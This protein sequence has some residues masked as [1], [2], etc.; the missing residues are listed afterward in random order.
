MLFHIFNLALV[1]KDSVLRYGRTR[2]R[3]FF[4]YVRVVCFN[5]RPNKTR[6]G[7]NF[8]FKNRIPKDLTSGVV[9]K[10][11]SGL[12]NESSYGECECVGEC[13]ECW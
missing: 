1:C 6:S 9:Y 4:S 2:T 10:F 5:Y 13:G 7:N 8:H 11:Q 3:G 12:C